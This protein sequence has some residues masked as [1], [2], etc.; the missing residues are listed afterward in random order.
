MGCGEEGGRGVSDRGEA[1]DLNLGR[2]PFALERSTESSTC[3]ER[4]W[5]ALI[6]VT[7]NE[8]AHD[9]HRSP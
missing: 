7:A 3:R 4:S 1:D 5:D 8:A 2:A 9:A 6:T